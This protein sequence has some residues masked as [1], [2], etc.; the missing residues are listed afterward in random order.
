MR[1]LLDLE[2]F[3]SAEIASMPP[4]QPSEAQLLARSVVQ[5]VQAERWRKAALASSLL[6]A[7]VLPVALYYG[8]RAKLSPEINL[9]VISLSPLSSLRSAERARLSLAPDTRFVTLVLNTVDI[10]PFSEYS[11]VI[12]SRADRE[13]LSL[14]GL[15]PS[16]VG[17]F[18]IGLP[19][20][21]FR[22]G[23]YH[24]KLFGLAGE[25]RDPIEEYSLE[26]VS[27]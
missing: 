27:L 21:R 1:S 7:L 9:P 19:T 24:L 3:S 16:P 11:L 8:T 18:N 14:G 26:I 25:K 2:S 22:P 13:I 17:T 5:Q 12:L 10:R 15:H 23:E 4:R 20:G 6:V